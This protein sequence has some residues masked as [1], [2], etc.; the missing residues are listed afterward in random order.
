MKIRGYKH[1][2]RFLLSVIFSSFQTCSQR[3]THLPPTWLSHRFYRETFYL[4]LLRLSGFAAPLL[5]CQ[6][7][8]RTLASAS[9]SVKYHS[10]LPRFR[11][12][13][14]FFFIFHA[15]GSLL[16]PFPS[17]LVFPFSFLLLFREQTREKSAT[18]FLL[19]ALLLHVL[20]AP[21]P[22]PPSLPPVSLAFFF[23]PP[24]FLLPLAE[25]F[26]FSASS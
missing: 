22:A 18:P 6:W 24:R 12:V 17:F 1:S 10:H 19:V 23:F 25:R 21:P 4:S 5:L 3:F 2:E 15:N 20:L 26:F 11:S 13:V 9:L 8:S 7:C 16:H 14:V